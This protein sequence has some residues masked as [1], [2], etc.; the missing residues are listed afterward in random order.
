[1]NAGAGGNDVIQEVK[2]LSDDRILVGGL[3]TT[4]NGTAAPRLTRLNTNGTLDTSFTVGT[5]PSGA[6][7]VITLHRR[8]KDPY[9]RTLR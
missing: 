6:V 9:R 7:N 8:R 3:F 4:Y 2:V 5:G 1:M